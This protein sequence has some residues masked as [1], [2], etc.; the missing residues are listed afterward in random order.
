LYLALAEDL[1]ADLA[2]LREALERFLGLLQALGVDLRLHQ[3]VE[4][5]QAAI[6]IP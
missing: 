1:R 3:P 6:V 5:R 2:A 4:G